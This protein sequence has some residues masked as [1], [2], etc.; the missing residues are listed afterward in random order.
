MPKNAGTGQSEETGHGRCER[1]VWY[2]VE[3]LAIVTSG[4]EIDGTETWETRLYV[5]SHGPRAKRL[6]H[7]IRKHRSIENCQHWTLDV[8][9]G[10]DSRRQ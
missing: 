2:V 7:A 9:F 1:R 4:R 6:A 10:E 8:I 5:S 3:T